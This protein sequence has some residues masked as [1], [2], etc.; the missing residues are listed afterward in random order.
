[1]KLIKGPSWKGKKRIVRCNICK[2][3]MVAELGECTRG[4]TIFNKRA[5]Y[6][7]CPFCGNSIFY[8]YD[9]K[10]EEA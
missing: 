4:K 10:Q 5:L 3:I 8:S 6:F 9:Y 7:Y 1:M 2:A